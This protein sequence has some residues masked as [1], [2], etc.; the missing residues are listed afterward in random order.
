[1]TGEFQII[2]EL[3]NKFVLNFYPN[4]FGSRYWLLQ[5]SEPK[6][7]VGGKLMNDNGKPEVSD[8]KLT[9]NVPK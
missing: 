1:M 8:T 2:L 3:L 4:N 6:N 9:M 7:F 5:V